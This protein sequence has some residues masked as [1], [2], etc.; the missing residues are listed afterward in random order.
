MTDT[1]A[2]VFAIVIFLGAVDIVMRRVVKGKRWL[3]RVAIPPSGSNACIVEAVEL[4]STVCSPS[5]PIPATRDF[6]VGR[7][8]SP[9]LSVGPLSSSC[10]DESHMGPLSSSCPDESHIREIVRPNDVREPV[11]LGVGLCAPPTGQ[12]QLSQVA[13]CGS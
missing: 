2:V 13:T 1:L 11:S 5:M 8:K 9:L 12:T 10:P 7:A 3:P 6:A 4:P